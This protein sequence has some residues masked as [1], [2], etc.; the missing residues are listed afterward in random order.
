[1]LARL[2]SSDPL[3][4]PSFDAETLEDF[5]RVMEIQIA[6]LLLKEKD[7]QK[8]GQRPKVD[9]LCRGE[10]NLTKARLQEVFRSTEAP[11]KTNVYTPW[12]P[13][14]NKFCLAETGLCPE[15]ECRVERMPVYWGE[16]LGLLL[17]VPRK[18]S[19]EQYTIMAFIR[20]RTQ[21]FTTT[22]PVW[23]Q[24][25]TYTV[26]IGLT[27]YGEQEA[28]KFQP[29]V[30]A[31]VK[32]MSN[33]VCRNYPRCTKGDACP[34]VHDAAVLGIPEVRQ[35][36][37][38]DAV[39]HRGPKVVNEH[40]VR[41]L[42]PKAPWSVPAFTEDVPPPPPDEPSNEPRPLQDHL[43]PAEFQWPES[44]ESRPSRAI[45]PDVELTQSLGRLHPSAPCVEVSPVSPL[46]SSNKIIGLSA[47]E[48]RR[49]DS[50][51]EVGLATSGSGVSANLAQ[52]TPIEQTSGF[53]PVAG[54]AR[55]CAEQSTAS[56]YNAQLVMPPYQNV[57]QYNPH[58]QEAMMVQ[59]HVGS[60][61]NYYLQAQP[62][63]QAQYQPHF[64][65]H[66][67]QQFQP[68][69]QPQYQ[70]VF[71][72]MMPQTSQYPA[73]PVPELGQ[74]SSERD[75]QLNRQQFQT[76]SQTPRNLSAD[77]TDRSKPVDL[78][79]NADPPAVF[80]TF[81]EKEDFRR[82]YE[83]KFDELKKLEK[84]KRMA[85]QQRIKD[86]Q[87][88]ISGAEARVAQLT[89]ENAELRL[90]PPCAENNFPKAAHGPSEVVSTRAAP[91]RGI[92]PAPEI[93]VPTRPPTLRPENLVG[94]IGEFLE[95]VRAQQGGY[96]SARKGDKVKITHHEIDDQT[97]WF[98]GE[99]LSG[100]ML[101]GEKGWFDVKLV[102]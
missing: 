77:A 61:G 27:P 72:G 24:D 100:E 17:G 80:S 29:Q 22:M 42:A 39:R 12:C 83:E 43:P 79:P 7:A 1:M 73:R 14:C 60:D 69:F 62:L 4:R 6:V 20:S 5:R 11:T 46:E 3:R 68:Q 66:F 35:V 36:G 91:E 95:D 57:A 102:R 90:R 31:M 10:G 40:T 21:F 8:S 37:V 93:R 64:Q 26:W 15:C 65:S 101:S 59:Y 74:L 78:P 98:Y 53:N 44:P 58:A 55:S 87:Q 82:E 28:R 51:N 32:H 88:R 30:D 19:P 41:H 81:V 99:L 50:A 2:E 75:G 70:Q 9:S 96:M 94:H 33:L 56:V 34:Y 89:A 45:T 85:L 67:Q 84:E 38:E 13:K 86:L 25:E 23:S 49:L 63:V 54:V 47:D 97:P 16:K 52:F 48:T 76:L 92:P 18:E 71:P